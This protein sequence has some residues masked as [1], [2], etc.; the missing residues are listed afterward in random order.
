MKSWSVYP[1][2]LCFHCFFHSGHE[3]GTQRRSKE[4]QE[5]MRDS[6]L[7]W[8]TYLFAS[9]TPPFDKLSIWWEN[10]P[11]IFYI[12]LKL[13]DIITR[14][15]ISCFQ[16]TLPFQHFLDCIKV[17]YKPFGCNIIFTFLIF[18]EKRDQ[19][20]QINGCFVLWGSVWQVRIV[21]DIISTEKPLCNV[22]GWQTVSCESKEED[23]IPL[24]E[25]F[26]VSIFCQVKKFFDK[27]ILCV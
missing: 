7:Y 10:K 9:F 18:G 12:F 3:I 26:L 23:V 6:H 27:L 19:I 8:S 4:V 1:S 20:L 2:L 22:S 24:L 21:W 13:S 14:I 11:F 16:Q 25:V 15:I 5:E 17:L